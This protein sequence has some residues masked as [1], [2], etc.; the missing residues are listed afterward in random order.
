MFKDPDKTPSDRWSV[1]KYSLE[2]FAAMLG[3]RDSLDVYRMSDFADDG[4]K[5]PAMTLAGGE[6]TDERVGKIRDMP[7]EGRGTPYASIQTAYDD[8]RSVDSANKWLVVLTDGALKDAAGATLVRKD[9][10]EK[11][12]GYTKETPGLS[13]DFVAIG[14]KAQEIT[15][16]RAQRV[17]FRAAKNTG[18]LTTNM[19]DIS[20]QI[21][22]RHTLKVESD[23]T[24]ASD[25]DLEELL[26]F[27]QGKDVR[28]GG[29]ELP[30]GE[31]L[32]AGSVVEV[33]TTDNNREGRPADV[34]PESLKGQLATFGNVPAGK[35]KL[36]VSAPKTVVFYKPKVNFG[37]KLSEVNTGPVELNDIDQG[38]YRLE[39]G[40]V[41]NQCEFFES[42]LLGDVEKSATII[43]GNEVPAEIKSGDVVTL[44][45]GEVKLA[46][47]ATYLDGYTAE[48]EYPVKVSTWQ[49]RLMDWLQTTG[50]K[51]ALGLAALIVALGYVFKR[52]F[53]KS[54]K[55]KPA[56][57]FRSKQF[58]QRPHEGRGRF[59]VANSRKFLPLPRR[60]GEPAV[61][62][63]RIR[64]GGIEGA[65]TEGRPPGRHGG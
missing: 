6:T 51:L 26:V 24:H 18:D 9:V 61:L 58:G 13:V 60:Q 35:M 36:D 46:L 20:N 28:I 22:E 64:G 52:R 17:Y 34:P 54:M 62:G 40:F 56:T 59:T 16:R 63:H 5:R 14:E 32:D 44:D 2:V 30:Q 41:N 47:K 11:L 19:T 21:F 37:I 42:K 55:A 48:A 45:P 8:I 50:W 29:I 57:T 7:L 38:D 23:G 1:A 33:A 4:S 49:E 39:Y 65:Q 12:S 25:I 31:H 15:E 53:P 10:E 27:A 43:R 3:E